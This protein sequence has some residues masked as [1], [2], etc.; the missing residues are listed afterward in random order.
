MVTITPA[1]LTKIAKAAAPSAV[2]NK[3][4]VAGIVKWWHI[5]EGAGIDTP[6][7]AAGFLGQSCI[8]TD[9]FKTLREY[10]GP[11]PTQK[12]YEGRKDLGN[13]EAGDG[14]RFMGRGIFQNTG[15]YN[16]QALSEEF[17]I[18]F[19]KEPELLETPEW[20]MKAAVFYWKQKKLEQYAAKKDWTR[21]SRGINR[22]NP[23]HK[24]AANHEAERIRA[25][26]AAFTQL[27][28]K[29]DPIRPKRYVD[30]ATVKRVQNQLNDLGWFEVGKIDGRMGYRTEGA[31]L[32]FRNENGLPNVNYIDDELLEALKT[33]NPRTVSMERATAT[34]ADLKQEGDETISTTDTQVKLAGAGGLLSLFG[35]ADQQGWTDRAKDVVDQVGVVRTFGDSLLDTLQWV[36]QK[37][38]LPVLM[39]CVYMGFKAWKIREKRVADHRSGKNVE[40]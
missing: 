11:T 26:Q 40:L 4:V 3:A 25:C 15:R 34:A 10:W 24:S 31:I 32:S 16:Y 38:W 5:A 20:S 37:W 13:T 14:K 6:A 18:D 8:E 33:A 19:T 28:S 39:L 9:Y 36:A 30:E 12:R 1:I 22:G 21:L 29:E 35:A 27:G 7:E 2:P 17:G 23:N